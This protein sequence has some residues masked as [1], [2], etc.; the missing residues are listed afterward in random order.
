MRRGK[1][2]NGAVFGG[3]AAKNSPERIPLFLP[4]RRGQGVR[5]KA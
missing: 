5:A 2:I 4:G 3:E 1:R